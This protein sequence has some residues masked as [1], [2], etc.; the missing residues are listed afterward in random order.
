M[1]HLF[2]DFDG[3]IADSEEGIVRSLK[4]AVAKM[5]L[6]E[7]THDQ[8]LKF[9]GPALINSLEKFYPQLSQGD[10]MT[11]LKYYH[12][13][14]KREGMFQLDLYPG[15]VSELQLLNDQGYDVNIASAKPEDL[16]HDI[17][18]Q[19]QITQ[20]FNG[21]YGASSDEGT[22]H[23]KTAV[24]KYALEEAKADHADSIM[25]GD[26]DNDMLG[27]YNNHVKTLGVTYGFGDVP[28]LLGAHANVL[29]D[30]PDEIQDGVRKII[31]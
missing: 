9:I 5:K 20:Y 31:G 11:T 4:Y 28:E 6:P 30:K 23:T 14:Y 18:D 22:R 8:Y 25:I 27:G 16:I 26:R 21:R 7:L 15:I 10:R 1:T 13:Y 2:F 19:F 17:T 29:V 24:L 3:T 12:D